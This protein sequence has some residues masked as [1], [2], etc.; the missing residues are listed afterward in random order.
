MNK[1]F[2]GYFITGLLVVVPVY[3]TFYILSTIVRF[4]DR[5]F[6]ILPESMRPDTYLPFH[7]PGLGIVFTFLGIVL[8]GLL[9]T[10]FLGKRILEAAENLMAKLPVVRIVYNSTK[11]FLETFFKQD[12]EGFRK[13]VL[14]EFPKAGV[15]SIGFLTGKLRGEL[16]DK[17]AENSVSVFLPTTPN[18]TTGYYVVLPEKDVI[19][20]EM[21]VEDA[22]KII[23]T[24]GMVVPNNDEFKNALI[25]KDKIVQ[26]TNLV[27][28]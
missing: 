7:I 13:V 20:L 15:W 22:F 9:T 23:I 21:K 12:H 2:K 4:L 6:V 27:N 5:V 8:V 10:N 25:S 14:I 19:P 17:T 26:N 16:K 3:I 1:S 11:Q 18:P 24:G 28:K